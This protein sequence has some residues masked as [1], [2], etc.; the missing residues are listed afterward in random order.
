MN[1]ILVKGIGMKTQKTDG[2]DTASTPAK[3]DAELGANQN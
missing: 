2:F 1:A 3:T